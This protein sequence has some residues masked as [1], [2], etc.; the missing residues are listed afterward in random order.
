[1]TH[2]FPAESDAIILRIFLYAYELAPASAQPWSAPVRAHTGP[3]ARY[4]IQ[5][6]SCRAWTKPVGDNPGLERRRIFSG[7]QHAEG[8]TKT[9]RPSQLSQQVILRGIG[10]TIG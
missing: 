4:W 2:S 9:S 1:M 3:A 6:P 8:K 5:Q 7:F 10:Y